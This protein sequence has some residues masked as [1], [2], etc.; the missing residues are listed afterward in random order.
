M[1]RLKLTSPGV[2]L[3]LAV[4]AAA[5]IFL[6]DVF[7]LR[8]HIDAQK[9]AAL[10][11]EAIRTQ[12]GT[13]LALQ[14]EQNSLLRTAAAWGQLPQVARFFQRP[15][16]DAVGAVLG[17]FLTPTGMEEAWI[18]DS[19]GN[20]LGIWAA[21]AN[22]PGPSSA[23]GAKLAKV[24]SAFSEYGGESL[25][26]LVRLPCGPALFARAP[27]PKAEDANTEGYLYVAR[28]VARGLL[29]RLSLIGGGELV[30]VGGDRLPAAMLPDHSVPQTVWLTPNE[31]L[32]VA[33]MARDPAGRDVG[34]FLA[35]VSVVHIHRQAVT[36]RRM[37]LIILSLSVALALL[38]ILGTHMLIIGPVVRL[39]TRLQRLEAGEGTAEN[40]A[41]DLHGEPLMLARRLENAFEKLAHISKTDELTGLANRRHFEEVLECFYY[42]A[43]RYNRPLSV[44]VMDIDFFKAVNDAGGHPAGDEMLKRVSA[45]I[46]DACRKADLP[47][48]FGGDEFAVLLPETAAPD[49]QAVAER[50]R[51]AISAHTTTV[52]SLKL[53]TTISIGVTDLNAGEMDGPGA[54]MGLADKALYTAKEL[55]RN[56]IVQAHSLNAGPAVGAHDESGRIDTLSKKLAGLDGQFKDLFI[57][58]FHEVMSILQTRDPHM[59][60]HTRKVQ[61]YAT[62]I[63]RGME[64]PDRVVTRI[65]ISAMMHDIGMVALPDSILLSPTHLDGEQMSLMRRHPLLSVRI[66]ER[67]EFLDQEIPAVRYHHERYDGK[68]YPEGIAGASIPLTA[69]ILAVADAFDAITSPRTFR[70]AKGCAEAIGEIRL[71]SG[72]QFDPTVVG[73][74]MAVAD[75][76]GEE[77]LHVP[78]LGEESFA[79]QPDDR[80]H[81]TSPAWRDDQPAAEAA[82]PAAAKDT[83]RPA[84]F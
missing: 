56:R 27:F 11:E 71:G 33:W 9:W 28:Q 15:D 81:F 3:I 49:A 72:T 18:T 70:N 36:S 79:P 23:Q 80:A 44:L 83:E 66:M 24:I 69:R 2:L 51:L 38:V 16:R 39:L 58:A 60:D 35:T 4:V 20:V 12:H 82:E 25:S 67:M 26:G 32:A 21:D 34:Y 64:L 40:L 63:A 75:R 37:V 43:R 6:L 1:T 65:G 5:G 77:L 41:R 52:G 22:H 13:E 84:E 53:N 10:R 73:A 31:H 17:S 19:A 54:M 57:Q 76:L 78:G 59:A 61:H 7:C 47:A 29:D 45:A 46:E 50:I 74:F 30:L 42:Q 55:G 62:L 14:A 48:R 68:G 8:P